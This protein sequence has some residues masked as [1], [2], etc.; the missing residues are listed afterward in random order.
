VTGC[1]AV[2]SQLRYEDWAITFMQVKKNLEA[3]IDASNE[4]GL[5]VHA[6]KAKHMLLSH[7]QNSGK[8]MT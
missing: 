7:H 6:E 3:L 4:V 1:D 5:E 2:S 8:I